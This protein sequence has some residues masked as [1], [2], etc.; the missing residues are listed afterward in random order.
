MFTKMKQELQAKG[1]RPIWV[2]TFEEPSKETLCEII[3]A[4]YNDTDVA[5]CGL[6]IVEA[7]GREMFLGISGLV[8]LIYFTFDFRLPKRLQVHPSSRP[9]RQAAAELR[10]H[11]TQFRAAV[12]WLCSRQTPSA[13]KAVQQ[14]PNPQAFGKPVPEVFKKAIQSVQGIALAATLPPSGAD[15]DFVRYLERHGR[16]HLRKRLD[17][18]GGRIVERSNPVH[19]VD[20][21]CAFLLDQCTNHEPDELPVKLCP[22]CEKLFVAKARKLYC[23]TQCQSK[24]FWTREKRADDMYVR[25]LYDYAPA[26]LRVKLATPRVAKRLAEIEKRWPSKSLIVA[27]IQE[28]RKSAVPRRTIDTRLAT[29]SLPLHRR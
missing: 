4:Y 13:V 11:S 17:V 28:I 23:T 16:T 7:F 8:N 19:I 26:T 25:R 10:R 1:E 24:T 22:R 27:N 12:K 6:K 14:N 29:S 15:V 18:W 20:L 5:D 2:F 9:Y 21:L 3:V